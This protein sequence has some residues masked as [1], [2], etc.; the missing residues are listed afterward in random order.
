MVKQTVESWEEPGTPDLAGMSFQQM[1]DAGVIDIADI[2]DTT[3]M[4]QSELV[5]IPFVLFD[6]DIKPSAEFGGHYAV[7]RVK[8]ASGT[9]VF[10]DGGAG[11]VEALERYEKRMNELDQKSPLYF[12]FG[13]RASTYQKQLVDQETGDTR[14]MTAT[15]YYFDNRRRP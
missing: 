2:D 8:T 1:M 7:C 13:L 11:I 12:H 3:I 9:A 14:T 15:T 5:G 4:E 10:S 6:W